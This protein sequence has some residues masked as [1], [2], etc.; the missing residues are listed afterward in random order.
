MLLSAE[1]IAAALEAVRVHQCYTR[2]AAVTGLNR[3][4]ISK[5]WLAAGNPPI[6]PIAIPSSPV[7]S[8]PE[9]DSQPR[10]RA[11]PAPPPAPTVFVRRRYVSGAFLSD[12][13]Y[14]FQH[15]HA[16]QATMESLEDQKPDMVILGGDVFDCYLLSR[17]NHSPSRQITLRDEIESAAGLFGWLDQIT[18]RVVFMMGN[19]DHRLD[20]FMRSHP[21]LYDHPDLTLRKLA[22]IPEHWEYVENQGHYKVGAVNFAHGDEK[23]R[24]YFGKYPARRLLEMWHDNFVCGHLHRF[25]SAWMKTLQGR[26]VEVH[27]NGHLSDETKAAR[28]YVSRPSW[29]MGYTWFDIYDEP[30][31]P[32]E[33]SQRVMRDG[34]M[35]AAGRLYGSPGV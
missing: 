9:A 32:F 26:T 20:A 2:A 7:Q 5:Y 19:H 24:E 10:S 14:P 22:R 11:V 21:A 30:D 16:I 1:K 4:T 13:H 6:N 17:F 27:F 35:L 15:K 28:E 34:R 29:Q 18:R 31:G 25:D 3:Q 33:I 8:V 23:G 12:L